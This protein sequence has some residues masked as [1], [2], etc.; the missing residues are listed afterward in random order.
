MINVFKKMC[1]NPSLGVTT[2]AKGACKVPSQEEARVSHHM[3][4]GVWK[5]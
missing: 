1:H 5:V 2:K 3:L 4:L